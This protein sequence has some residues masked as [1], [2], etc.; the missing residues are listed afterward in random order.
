[1]GLKKYLGINFHIKAKFY[2]EF[3]PFNSSAVW[4]STLVFEEVYTVHAEGLGQR[5]ISD[6]HAEVFSVFQRA[7]FDSWGTPYILSISCNPTGLA[8]PSQASWAH[9]AQTAN[10]SLLRWP[11]PLDSNKKGG[12]HERPRTAD[13]SEMLDA[14]WQASWCFDKND[15]DKNTFV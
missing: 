4:F 13:K 2:W 14:C 11:Y 5:N 6:R 3:L 15:E 9:Y 10:T 12:L 1:M 8:Q 7:S